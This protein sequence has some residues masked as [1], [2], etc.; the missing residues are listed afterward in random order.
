MTI[1]TVKP[2]AKMRVGKRKKLVGYQVVWRIIKKMHKL[3]CNLTYFEETEDG[4][5]IMRFKE[6]D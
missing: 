5:T 4:Y 1:I 2:N 6:D 3:G